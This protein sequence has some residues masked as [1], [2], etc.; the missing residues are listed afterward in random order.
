MKENILFNANWKIWAPLSLNIML[1]SLLPFINYLP[2]LDLYYQ[3]SIKDN[4]PERT[5]RF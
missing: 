1:M 2:L 5:E 3:I 4:R